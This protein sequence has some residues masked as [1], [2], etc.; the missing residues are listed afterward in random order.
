MHRRNDD[1]GGDKFDLKHSE[2]HLAPRDIKD[3]LHHLYQFLA[4]LNQ[5]K[6]NANH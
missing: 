4:E 1:G 3:V 5:E 6:Q 2:N